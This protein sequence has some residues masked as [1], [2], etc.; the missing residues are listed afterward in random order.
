MA[1]II[2]TVRGI[3]LSTNF[4]RVNN[5]L[6]LTLPKP[7]AGAYTLRVT[8]YNVPKGS[9]SYALVAS[10]AISTTEPQAGALNFESAEYESS[11]NAGSVSLRVVRTSGST[12]ELSVEYCTEDGTAQAG[13]DYQPVSGTLSWADGDQTPK[14]F[15]VPILNDNIAEG[16]ETVT[17]LLQKPA[18]NS[19]LNSVES[20]QLN[21]EDDAGNG[22][23]SSGG[24]FIDSMS[25]AH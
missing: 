21:I 7:E 10:G 13:T 22:G 20:A 24:C 15:I 25:F 3:N 1:W 12:G 8:G 2:A 14:E 18:E 17:L 4:D 5:V 19:W 9:Q 6:G 16:V 23:G 11:E